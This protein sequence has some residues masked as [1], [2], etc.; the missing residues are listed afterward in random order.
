M[1]IRKISRARSIF[2]WSLC[3]L[4]QLG[5]LTRIISSRC[6]RIPILGSRFSGRLLSSLQ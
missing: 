5:F 4:R 2:C 3:T 1:A 6:K